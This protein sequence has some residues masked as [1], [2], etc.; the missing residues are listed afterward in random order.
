MSPVAVEKAITGMPLS[1]VE[2]TTG[3]TRGTGYAFLIP[4]GIEGIGKENGA[5]SVPG[6]IPN[7][8]GVSCENDI[9]Q[10]PD[11]LYEA[12]KKR[13]EANIGELRPCGLRDD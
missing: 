2:R 4:K 5:R 6:T 1:V 13:L 3:S 9:L 7:P 11:P 8:D 10:S 12:R